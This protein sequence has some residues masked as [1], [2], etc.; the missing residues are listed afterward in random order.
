MSGNDNIHIKNYQFMYP[1]VAVWEDFDQLQ[2]T[3]GKKEKSKSLKKYQDRST[4][5]CNFNELGDH[6]ERKMKR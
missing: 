5:Y 2:V 4:T 3:K 6:N 1:S